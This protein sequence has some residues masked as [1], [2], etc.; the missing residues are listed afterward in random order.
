MRVP[1]LGE[2]FK[3][4]PILFFDG[5]ALAVVFLRQGQFKSRFGSLSDLLDAA[6]SSLSFDVTTASGAIETILV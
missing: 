6:Q 5:G 2:L 3:F 4:D 1:C